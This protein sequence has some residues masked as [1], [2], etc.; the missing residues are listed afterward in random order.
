MVP[1][2]CNNQPWWSNPPL[3]TAFNMLAWERPQEASAKG[4]RLQEGLQAWTWG[5]VQL[6]E[7]C[8][9]GLGGSAIARGL[10]AWTQMKCNCKRIASLAIASNGLNKEWSC[11]CR[12]QQK[13]IPWA[14][15]LSKAIAQLS[16]ATKIDYASRELDKNWLRKQWT[17]QKLV[18][19]VLDS[20]QIDC[21]SIGI[22][23]NWSHK[24]Q[25]QQNWSCKRW[26]WQQWIMQAWTWQKA[27]QTSPKS[28]QMRISLLQRVSL[29]RAPLR[30]GGGWNGS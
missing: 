29:R 10:Q 3:R 2:W 8:K 15:N 19:R 25:N 20:T 1:L 30:W 14:S 7:D 16:D 9:H 17:R 26:N 6:Q 5:E 11:N 27:S 4:K 24:C 18:T 21:A 28:V 13:P 22:N 12:T 23:N